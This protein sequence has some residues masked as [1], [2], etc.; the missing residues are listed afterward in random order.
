MASWGNLQPLSTEFYSLLRHGLFLVLFF[1]LPFLGFL[2][3]GSTVS[4]LLN[5]LGKEKRDPSYLR[6]SQELMRTV[7]MSKS[8][9]FLFGL[10]PLLLVW[11]IYARVLFDA[12]PLPWQFWAVI[13]TVLLFGFVLLSLYR[14]ARGRVLDLSPI[15]AATGAAGLLALILAFFLFSAGYGILFNPSKLP[16]LQKQIRFF[17]SW[18]AVVKFLLFL[19]FFFGM[20]GAAILL[21]CGRSAEG[22]EGTEAEY[23]GL[24]HRFGVNLTFL[25]TLVLPVFLLLDLVTLPEI[26][27]SAE[28]FVSSAVVLLLSLAVCLTL[29]LFDGKGEGG[30][31]ARGVFLFVLIFLA[32]LL[33]DDAA[34]GNAYQD[35]IAFLRMQATAV[36]PVHAKEAPRKEP[37]AAAQVGED[38]GKVVFETI[39]AGCHRF[40]M[41][42]VGPPLSEVVPKY[43]GDAEKLKAF[44]RAPVKVNPDYPS[45]PKLG[46]PEEEIDAVARYLIETVK[47]GGS[48]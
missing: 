37:A 13:F 29:F 42:V 1:H 3:G 22:G 46:L 40:D 36:E 34:V 41:R 45:M 9:L 16:L 44:I 2:I 5:F 47:T 33:H 19:A 48:K 20:T 30:P 14:S 6:F 23:Q 8:A 21:L 18:N 38:A 43:G 4:L 10:V 25:A 28:V 31:G 26:A 39:C 12:S 27:L 32:M 15:S 17:L 24:V 7:L 11:F 35:R